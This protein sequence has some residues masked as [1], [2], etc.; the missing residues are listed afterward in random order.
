MA[1]IIGI[2]AY[3]AIGASATAW[4]VYDVSFDRPP[5]APR[6]R[7]WRVVGNFWL[8]VA[9]WLPITVGA[10]IARILDGSDA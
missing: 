9:F 2:G 5:S 6:D 10:T 3:L 7:W 8:A 1:W 4:I